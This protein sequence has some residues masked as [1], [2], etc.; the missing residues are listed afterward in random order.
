[1]KSFNIIVK[2]Y[3]KR[4]DGPLSIYF[5][6][7]SRLVSG[8]CLYDVFTQTLE[9]YK[10]LLSSSNLPLVLDVRVD[11]KIDYILGHTKINF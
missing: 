9:H 10:E 5:V 7:Q 4:Q 6:T 1:M 3:K 2:C 11:S 8:L